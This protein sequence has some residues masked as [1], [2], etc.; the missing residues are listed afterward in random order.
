MFHC[1]MQWNQRTNLSISCW[2]ACEMSRLDIW[3]FTSDSNICFRLNHICLFPQTAKWVYEF[4]WSASQSHVKSEKK[5]HMEAV[6]S[7]TDNS[8]LNVRRITLWSSLLFLLIRG[9][10]GTIVWNVQNCVHWSWSIIYDYGF[11][12]QIF[13]E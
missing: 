12:S 13:T 4:F 11:D 3:V 5:K 6:W 8:D 10:G 2:Y 9:P 1:V 7:V